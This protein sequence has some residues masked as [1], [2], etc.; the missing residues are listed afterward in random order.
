MLANQPASPVSE[1]LRNAQRDQRLLLLVV[2]LNIGNITNL[3]RHHLEGRSMVLVDVAVALMILIGSWYAYRQRKLIKQLQ[4]GTGTTYG[5]IRE[6]IRQIRGLMRTKFYTAIAFLVTVILAIA[7]GKHVAILE[8]LRTDPHSW[9]VLALGVGAA[10]VVIGLLLY[11]SKR[12]QQ[13]R[14]G[15]HLDRLEASLRELDA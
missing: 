14:Y 12:R 4:L 1:M 2:I 8:A 13:R 9:G 11:V 5:H 3:S 15:R 10:V 7:Y 6:S